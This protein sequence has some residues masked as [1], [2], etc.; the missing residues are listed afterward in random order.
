M[1]F[2]FANI[3]VFILVGLGFILVNLAV[4]WFL[5]PKGPQSGETRAI[6]FLPVAV[7]NQPV[8]LIQLDM[9]TV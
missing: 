7:A 8:G 3:L 5:R 6:Y 2:D 4:A 1:F 9:S